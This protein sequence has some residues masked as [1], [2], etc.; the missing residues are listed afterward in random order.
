MHD[1]QTQFVNAAVNRVRRDFADRVR[2]A[3]ILGSGLGDLADEMSVDAEISYREIPH[4]VRSTAAGHEGKLVCGSIQGVPVVA[5]K[6]RFHLYEG[7]SIHEVTLPVR[8]MREL[9]AEVLIASN[10]SGGLNPKFAAGDLMLLHDHID[11]LFGCG[12]PQAAVCESGRSQH[13]D[14]PYCNDLV[15]KALRIARAGDFVAHRGV[16]IGVPGPNYE[17]RSE[18]RMLRKLGGDVVGMSTIPEVTAASLLG[19]RVMAIS[20]VTNVANPDAPRTVYHEEVLAS[21]DFVGPKMRKI[22]W[23]TVASL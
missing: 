5:M 4:F 7:Y 14:S 8:V 21:A 15:A 2:V 18:I 6:G 23:E 17:T 12:R 11:M 3:L 9:G 20:V 13:R 16:Y 10:A 19:M 1:E 22:V